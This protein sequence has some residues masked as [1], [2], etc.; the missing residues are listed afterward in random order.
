MRRSLLAVFIILLLL[1]SASYAHTYSGTKVGGAITTGSSLETYPTAYEDEIWGGAHV[2]STSAEMWAIPAAR[3]AEGMTCYVTTEGVEYRLIGG[4]WIPITSEASA[5]LGP[6]S[7]EGVSYNNVTYPNVGA[8]LDYLL[9]PPVV[10]TG[11]TITGFSPAAAEIGS[12]QSV[13]LD[14]TSGGS[15][16]IT[17]TTVNATDMSPVD[18]TTY[19]DTGVTSDK[20]YTVT[21][22]RGS[23]S[24]ASSPSSITFYWKEYWGMSTSSSLDNAGVLALGSNALATARG[25]DI[26][27]T[28]SVSQEYIYVAYPTA[29]DA[30][31]NPRFHTGFGDLNGWTMV[32]IASFTNASGGG[33][34][35]Y[36]VWR[37]SIKYNPPN[38]VTFTVI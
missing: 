37:S 14:W 20:S 13:T 1:S 33:P 16:T 11:V 17:R 28:P 24:G 15:G 18:A 26:T 25:R 35:S 36:N 22:Y 2:T 10:P 19:T 5:L 9:T 4:I 6:V 8:A 21:V 34:I 30:G 32:A 7:A 12:T 31:G 38:P 3:E 23:N 29:W 27:V